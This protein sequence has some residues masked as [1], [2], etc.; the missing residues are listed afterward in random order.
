ML[1]P[2]GLLAEWCVT[3]KNVTQ[4]DTPQDDGVDEGRRNSPRHN[5][6]GAAPSV[7]RGDCTVTNFTEYEY[8]PDRAR[9]LADAV[10]SGAS[11]AHLSCSSR[12]NRSDTIGASV[13][14]VAE[15]NFLDD[16][17]VRNFTAV[18]LFALQDIQ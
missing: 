18:S 11:C 7:V 14:L 4:N 1:A 13:N 9:L 17:F 3:P 10:R 16:P 6:G 15:V 2:H 8:A 12:S 5:C